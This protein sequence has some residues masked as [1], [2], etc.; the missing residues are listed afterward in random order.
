MVNCLGSFQASEI[1]GVGNILAIILEASAIP[2]G[3]QNRSQGI[4]TREGDV[5]QQGVIWVIT[6]NVLNLFVQL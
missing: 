5:H 2:G 3:G 1:A 4:G 6:A